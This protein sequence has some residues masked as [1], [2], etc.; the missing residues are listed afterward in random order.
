MEHFPSAVIFGCS[1]TSFPQIPHLGI[2]IHREK[3]KLMD[4]YKLDLII[5]DFDFLCFLSANV[6]LHIFMAQPPSNQSTS[7]S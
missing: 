2:Y 5:E 6:I 4:C 7:Q 3:P 1:G